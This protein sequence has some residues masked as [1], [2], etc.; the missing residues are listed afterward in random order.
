L[1]K[2]YYQE[3]IYNDSYRLHIFTLLK[4]LLKKTE[5]RNDF[6]FCDNS[7]D[8]DIVILPMSWNYYYKKKLVSQVMQYTRGYDMSDKPV[9]SIIVGDTGSKVPKNFKGFVL[10]A[11]GD[12]SKL[13]SQHLGMPIFV[14]DPLKKYFQT[15]KVFIRPFTEKPVVGFC[16]LANPSRLKRITDVLRVLTK[17]ILS[18]LKYYHSNPQRLMATAYFRY[19]ILKRLEQA[20]TITTN[21]IIRDQYRAGIKSNKDNHHTTME[22]YDNIKNSDYVVCM[23]GAGNF[24]NRFYE[25]LAMGRIPVFINTDCLLPLEDKIEWKKHVV[26]VEYKDRHFIEAKINEFHSKLDENSLNDLFECNRQLW[27]KHLQI[28]P[29][30]K[31]LLNEI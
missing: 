15:K 26:W 7:N 4:L 3:D 6:I 23:R 28:L 31:T 25:T 11:S 17:N 12:K 18:A 22:F 16:G 8:A 19:K 21:F 27:L 24:S 5:L 30:F 13:S 14:E 20:K 1:K 2:I 9:F 10:R 29:Y